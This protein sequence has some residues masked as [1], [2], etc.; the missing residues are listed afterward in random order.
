MK[1]KYVINIIN[2]EI[3]KLY[4]LFIYLKENNLFLEDSYLNIKIVIT[5]YIK[6]LKTKENNYL[7]NKIILKNIQNKLLNECETSNYK[8]IKYIY[9][10]IIDINNILLQNYKKLLKRKKY[11][12]IFIDKIHLHNLTIKE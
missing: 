2:K 9:N 10:R 12:S 11:K 3:K 1:R 7:I 6:I 5:T 8:S 4:D